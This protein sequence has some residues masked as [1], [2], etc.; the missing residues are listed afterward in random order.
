LVLHWGLAAEDNKIV[1]IDCVAPE[2]AACKVRVVH[3]TRAVHV[4]AVVRVKLV[5]IGWAVFESFVV[6][7]G[8]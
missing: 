6:E 4:I 1:P 7:V 8:M 2:L 3:K 5:D